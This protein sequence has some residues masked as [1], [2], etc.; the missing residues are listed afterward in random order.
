MGTLIFVLGGARSGKSSFAEKL[1]MQSGRPVLYVATA[2]ALDD[3]MRE[4]IRKH[5]ERRPGHWRTLEADHHTGEAAQATVHPD[6]LVL[7]DCLTLLVSN[8]I[9]E[10]GEDVSLEV[11]QPRVKAEVDALLA[12]ARTHAAPTI[13]VSNEVGLGGVPLYPLG[14]VYQ[15]LLGWANQE[16]AAE[17]ELV[18]WVVAGL[19]VEIKKLAT[20]LGSPDAGNCA[21]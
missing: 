2:R 9:L 3:E 1:A 20:S 18:Y 17:A 13:L 19:P 6:E 21:E 8:V 5:Q 11:A 10:E 16:A 14:R 15:D 12:L 4:R 7:I